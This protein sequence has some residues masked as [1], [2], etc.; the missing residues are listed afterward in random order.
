MALKGANLEHDG[1]ERPDRWGLGEDLQ[2]VAGRWGIDPQRDL[3][4]GELVQRF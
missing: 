3:S 2:A 1:S 4:R